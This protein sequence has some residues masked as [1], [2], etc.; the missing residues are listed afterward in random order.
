MDISYK[1]L[2]LYVRD[3]KTRKFVAVKHEQDGITYKYKINFKSKL[4]PPISISKTRMP[5]RKYYDK[6][7]RFSREII[8]KTW[9]L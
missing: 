5:K 8:S 4:K 7:K 9:N 2:Q 6:S 1:S 3:P